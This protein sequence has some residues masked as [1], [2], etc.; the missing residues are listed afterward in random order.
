MASYKNILEKV[1]PLLSADFQT[2]SKVFTLGHKGCEGA[3]M[4]F[5]TV[6]FYSFSG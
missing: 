2:L 1:V 6:I 3:K 4:K 5:L